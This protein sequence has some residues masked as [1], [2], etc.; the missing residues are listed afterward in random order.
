MND[1]V[2]FLLDVIRIFWENGLLVVCV[3]V[4]IWDDKVVNVF[5]VI[6]VLGC[7]VNMKIVEDMWKLIG[8]FLKV[9]GFLW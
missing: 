4:I 8:Y 3:D 9:K 1:C 2:G 5:Y 6:D 7:F